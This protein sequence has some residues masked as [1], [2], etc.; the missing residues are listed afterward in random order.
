MDYLSFAQMLLNNGSLNGVRVLGRKTVEYM[1]ADHL[2][3]D[4]NIDRLRT[5]RNKD[6]YGF[7]LG[8]AVRRGAG[9]SGMMGSA[10][11]FHWGGAFGTYFWVDP[12]ENIAAVFMSAGPGDIRPYH[13]QMMAGLVLQAI[14][15]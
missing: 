12:Q 10:G 14:E 7:G 8:V 11:D 13:R 2:G 6:G 5:T 9:V 4:V 15:N 1:T 3:P